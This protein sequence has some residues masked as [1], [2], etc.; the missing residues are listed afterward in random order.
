MPKKR[1][2]NFNYNTVTIKGHQYYKAYVQNADEKTI[3]VYG[4]TIEDLCGWYNAHNLPPYETTR[5]FIGVDYK[6]PRAFGIYRDG[7][8]FVVYKNKDNGERAVRYKGP[9][10]AYAVN[11]IYLKLK[12]VL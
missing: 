6:K 1:I 8:E 12:S 11:E 7:N 10:E 5:F 4:K 3:I 2:P 9:D